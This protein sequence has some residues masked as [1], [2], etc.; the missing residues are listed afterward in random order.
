MDYSLKWPETGNFDFGKKNDTIG[1]GIS[2]G[3]EWRKF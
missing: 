1:K 3:A 2:R